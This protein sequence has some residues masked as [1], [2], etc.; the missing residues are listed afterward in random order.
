M[1]STVVWYR[2]QLRTRIPTVSPI[3]HASDVRGRSQTRGN[4]KGPTAQTAITT[5]DVRKYHCSFF[6]AKRRRLE[7]SRNSPQC[8]H[9]IA[10]SWISSA[11]NGHF[12]IIISLGRTERNTCPIVLGISFF[13]GS[14]LPF[15]YSTTF[16]VTPSITYR[17]D[18]KG[19]EAMQQYLDSLPL[20]LLR[21]FPAGGK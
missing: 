1:D 7:A 9:F 3:F 4:A 14:C 2:I 15:R 18:P 10:S 8:L 17:V 16:R 19:V 6:S 11:Q 21:A 13:V 20:T 12:F 5:K